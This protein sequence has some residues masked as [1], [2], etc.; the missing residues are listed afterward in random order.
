M[1]GATWQEIPAPRYPDWAELKP[2]QAVTLSYLWL[3]TPGGAD[4]P[5]RLYIGT[6]PGGLF[7]SDDGGDSFSLV[8]SLWNCP[9]RG[10]IGGSA[11]VVTI[12]ACVRLWSIRATASTFWWG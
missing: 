4:Q 1:L 10:R 8:E 5:Q 11:A 2:G 7:V 9:L 12:L 3:L 6:E